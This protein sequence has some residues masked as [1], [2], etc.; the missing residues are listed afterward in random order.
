[1][2]KDLREKQ[3]RS[4]EQYDGSSRS[5]ILIV[6]SISGVLAVVAVIGTVV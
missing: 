5:T 2:S 4:V 3:S 6:L 1:M